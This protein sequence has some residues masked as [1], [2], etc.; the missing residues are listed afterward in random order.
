ME[1]KRRDRERED[2]CRNGTEKKK[3]RKVGGSD[4][5]PSLPLFLGRVIKRAPMEN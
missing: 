4:R 3:R 2:T 1:K 5:L